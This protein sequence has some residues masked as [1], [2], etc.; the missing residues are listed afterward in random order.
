MDGKF[1]DTFSEKSSGKMIHLIG[2]LSSKKHS[3]SS[4]NFQLFE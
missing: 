3:V 2:V 4:A 1:S